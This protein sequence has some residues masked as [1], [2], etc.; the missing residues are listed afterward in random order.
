MANQPQDIEL[1][2]ICQFWPVDDRGYGIAAKASLKQY[3]RAFPRVHYLASVDEPFDDLQQWDGSKV[4]WIHVRVPSRAQW[5]YFL[6]SLPRGIPA[7]VT[8]H[9][10]A[11]RQVNQE[12]LRIRREA[13]DRGREVAVI[14]EDLAVGCLLPGL[15]RRLPDVA[16]AVRSHNVWTKAFDGFQRDGR[17]PERLAWR[18]E[19]HKL[20][21]HEQTASRLADRFWAI[22]ENDA[23]EYTDRL[24]IRCHGVL[25]VSMEAARYADVQPGSPLSVVHMGLTDKRKAAG[26]R[27]FISEAWPS[28]RRQVPQARLVLAGRGSDRLADA[29]LGIDGLGFVTDEKALLDK[30]LIF[31]NPQQIGSGVKLKSIVAMLAGKALVATP[32][33]IEGVW[34]TPGEHFFVSEDLHAMSAQVVD[35]LGSCETTSQVAASARRMAADHYSEDSLSGTVLPLLEDFANLART[36]RPSTA[37][38]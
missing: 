8:R 20:R 28:I 14:F 25:G 36:G 35:L 4:D 9:A 22:S 2:L 15:R 32:T 33:G 5:L 37:G 17:L 11:A 29:E 12:V 16:M 34:G 26:L 31:V 6:L 1:I 13:R 23:R 38:R 18:L 30:G 3:V 10:P 7:S 24:G 19:L 27:R 21:R